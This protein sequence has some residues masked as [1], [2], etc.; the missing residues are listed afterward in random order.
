MEALMNTTIVQSDLNRLSRHGYSLVEVLI[1]VGLLAVIMA[2]ALTFVTYIGKSTKSVSNYSEMNA[3]KRRTMEVMARDVRM[4]FNVISASTKSMDIEVYGKGN[5]DDRI[6]YTYDSAKGELYRLDK[7]IIPASQTTL[8]ENL[9][10]FS[11][12]FY[13]SDGK[14]TTDLVAIKE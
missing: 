6:T 7:S 4:C 1:V 10:S 11:F 5:S 12:H 9:S 13:D 3:S 2:F 14:A 8:L